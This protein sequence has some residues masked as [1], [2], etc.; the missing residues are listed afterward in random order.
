MITWP[1]E[2]KRDLTAFSDRGSLISFIMEGDSAKATWVSRRVERTASFFIDSSNNVTVDF[3]DSKLSYRAFLSHHSMSDLLGISL[4]MQQG[5]HASFFVQTRAKRQDQS[6]NEAPAIDL[7]HHAIT[8]REPDATTVVFVNGDAGSGKTEAIKQLVYAQAKRYAEGEA[9]FLYLYVNAQ[10]RA[11]ARLD[12]ALATEIQDLRA[13]SLTYHVV[14]SLTRNGV[15]IPIIDG[16]DELL[17][18]LG[19]ED[20]FSSLRRFLDDLNG[21]GAIIASARSTY[22]QQE[23]LHRSGRQSM[24]QKALI[25]DPI[26]ILPWSE[27]EFRSYIDKRFAQEFHPEI[28]LDSFRESM[29]LAFAASENAGLQ[30]KPFF[31]SKTADL[32]LARV[33]VPASNLIGELVAGYVERER[34]EKLLDRNGGP[35]LTAAEINQFVQSVSEEMWLTE[36]RTLDSESVRLLAELS[37]P[38]VDIS[39]EA[40]AILKERAPT[41]AF[42]SPASGRG[43]VEFEHSLFFSFFLSNIITKSFC[44]GTDVL[45]FTLS[46]GVLPENSASFA[47]NQ[48]FEKQFEL[49]KIAETCSDVARIAVIKSPQARENAGSIFSAA[50]RTALSSKAASEVEG[51]SVAYLVFSGERFGSGTISSLKIDHSEFNAC[52]FT[53]IK[54]IDC[55]AQ[56][57][58]MR[59]IVVDVATTVVDIRGIDPKRDIFGLRVRSPDGTVQIFRHDAVTDILKKCGMPLP[60]Q[61]SSEYSLPGG[62]ID[63]L[64]KIMKKF[65]KS[66]MFWPTDH[67]NRQ[68]LASDYWLSIE[69]ALIESGVVTKES[70]IA[71]AGLPRYALRRRFSPHQIMYG[72]V[73]RTSRSENIS[74]F[75]NS[76]YAQY[77]R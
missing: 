21:R 67:D 18:V 75:W 2:I 56:D 60:E 22:Y 3:E 57:T 35:L 16:F 26:D 76:L 61:E 77:S 7:L 30:G 49:K 19:Y 73:D 74:K 51:L 62:L 15:L 6:A 36:T 33:H 46:R 44:D 55:E 5:D 17:G 31:V 69:K 43:R 28:P 34:T 68:V 52:D 14:P 42:F 38:G 27:T 25:I 63:T 8:E 39:S 1:E 23:F 9:D 12:E 20:S 45:Y 50:I 37:F 41:M 58:Q 40:Q 48:L 64:E 13:S 71:H 32:I 66:N 65:E 72:D 47:A 70:S 24:S 11:L 10:G 59:D 54:M 4:M 29:R 53:G